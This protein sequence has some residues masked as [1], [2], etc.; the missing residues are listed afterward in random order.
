MNDFRGSIED[1]TKA[2]KL[3]PKDESLYYDRGWSKHDL[4]DY[5]GAIAD[6]T[7]S[8]ILNP[9]YGN[10]YLG[11]GYSKIAIKDKAGAC[12]DFSKAGELGEE[13]AY[14]AINE[15]CN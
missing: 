7:K 5:K 15:N 6:F 13:K 3:E 8:I 1:Y 4:K 14:E 10:S 2:I 12:K 11:R 9:N